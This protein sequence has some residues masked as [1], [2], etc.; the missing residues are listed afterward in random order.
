ME[1]LNR[2]YHLGMSLTRYDTHLLEKRQ[3]NAAPLE[4]QQWEYECPCGYIWIDSQNNGC[5]MCG[6]TVG[7]IPQLYET[8][9]PDKFAKREK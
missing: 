6:N 1:R 3:Y 8:K 4:E 5:P 9:H 2:K 7:I